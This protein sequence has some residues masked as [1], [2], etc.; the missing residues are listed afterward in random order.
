MLLNCF[1]STNTVPQSKA[2]ATESGNTRLDSQTHRA[3]ARLVSL[4]WIDFRGLVCPSKIG[5]FF[6]WV[7]EQCDD[8]IDWFN[9]RPT[10]R[11]VRY[12]HGYKS[13]RGAIYAH[14]PT[15][16][17]SKVWI[18]LPSQAL[19]GA[20]STM[21]VLFVAARCVDMGLRCTRLDLCLDDATGRLAA[22]RRSI[23][24]AYNAGHASGFKK[25]LRYVKHDSPDAVPQ[26]T[27]YLGSRESSSY[28]RI[29]D[30]ESGGQRWERQTGRDISDTILADL[31]LCH[32]SNRRNSTLAEYDAALARKIVSHLTNGID[33]V[34]RKDKNLSRGTRC[35]FWQQFLTWLASAQVKVVRQQPKPLLEKTFEW[36]DHQVSKSFALVRR[37]LGQAYQEWVTG[38]LGRGEAKF[39]QFDF[40][41][42]NTYRARS[43]SGDL[44]GIC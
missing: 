26:E 32:E 17:A 20:G 33:F 9:D 31:L 8:V 43:V 25:L 28:V 6:A 24:R 36:L 14:E 37:V 42:I 44:L 11:H 5:D 29:Y 3:E 7:A 22:L 21:A 15:A 16:G 1:D 30:R 35:E 10:G 39:K 41:R 23:C 18:S 4:D 12:S 2:L 19:A 40:D 38:F 13:A 34:R 27:A